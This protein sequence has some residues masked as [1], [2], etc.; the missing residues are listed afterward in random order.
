MNGLHTLQSLIFALCMWAAL[1]AVL[2]AV[3]AEAPDK[4]DDK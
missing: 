1:V 3:V 4:K 2:M